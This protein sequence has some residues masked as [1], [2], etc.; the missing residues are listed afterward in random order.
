MSKRILL[1]TDDPGSGGVAQYNHA[2]LLGLVA[3]EYHVICVQSKSN[4]PLI[5][6]QKE[7]G[8]QHVWL[9]FDTSKDFERSL[10]N[11]ADA[12]N[13]LTIYK[14]DFII[15]SDCCPLSNFAAKQVAIELEIPYIAVI[16][17]VAAYLAN[18]FAT[19]LD[20]LARQYTQAKAVIAVSND[21]L[22]LLHELFRLPKDKGRVIYY[23]RPAEYFS[24]S[25]LPVRQNLRQ[26]FN[27]PLNA[28]VCFTS[29]RLELVKGYQYQL[30]AI[31]HLKQNEVWHKLY[32]VWAGA[33]SLEMQLKE[34]IEQLG[35]GNKV[36]LLGQRWD[37]TDWLDASDIFILP[38]ELEGMP[39]CIMEAMAK[40]LPVI[41]SAVSG[42]PEEL[43]DT[44]KL[45]PSPQINSQATVI[46][47]V[48]TIQAWCASLGLRQSIGWTCKKRAEEMFRAERMVVET[49]E[50]IERTLLPIGDY[51][52]PGFSIIQPDKC[53]PNLITGD[54]N[55][56]RWP[57]LRRDI[58][59]NWYVDKRQPTVGFLNRD[60]VHILYNTALN[61][62]G[63]KALE[64]GCWLGWS[65]CHLALAG[66]ELDVVDPL[67]DR[68]EFYESV[69]S[70][71]KAAGV[72]DSVNLVSGYSPQKVEELAIQ[73]QRKWS[74]IFIDGNHDA[75]FP[76]KDA[77]ICEQLAEK[78][79]LILFH[80]LVSPDVAQ[81]LKYLKQKRWNT[82]VYQTMQIMGVAWRGNVKPVEH[83]P[84]LKVSKG[85][86]EH[87]QHFPVSGLNNHSIKDEFSEVFNNYTDVCLQ[88]KAEHTI[89]PEIKN[90]E[91]FYNIQILIREEDIKTILEIGSSTGEG[92]T[93]A[94]VTAIRKKLD[95]PTLFCMEVAKPRFAEL[96]K[97]YA[98]DSFVKCYNISSVSLQDF[99]NQ[100]EV[101][102]FYDAH[103]TNLNYYSLDRILS[104]LHQDIECIKN[105]K[106]TEG[107]IKKIKQENKIHFFDVV[108]IDGSE[109]TG[110][111]E[112]D[113][114]YGA[115]LVLLDDINTFKNYKNYRRLLADTNYTLV[116]QNF[117]LR[118]G[119]AIFKKVDN[120]AIYQ[121]PALPI[122]FF[123]I[124]LN[125]EPFIRYHI[126]VFKQLP[127]QW[128]WHII[129]GVAELKHDT[130]WSLRNGGH[131]TNEFHRNGRSNDGTT[132][133][134]DELARLYPENITVYRKPE[135]VFWDGKRQMVNAPLA[136]INEECLLWQVDA[137]EL[138][139]VEQIFTA[140]KMFIN[141][142]DKTAAF[143]WCWYFV[144]ENLVISTRNCYSQN[145]QQEWL[146]TW[147]FKPGLAWATHEPPI[148]VE[149][150]SNG[151][152]RNVAA[153][154]PFL[155]K[156]TENQGLVFQHFA[157]VTL[158]QLKFKEQYYGYTNAV[159]QWKA[160]QTQHQFPVLL[161]ECCSW[162]QDET[163]VDTVESSGVEPIAKREPVGSP[164]CSAVWR[165]LQPEGFNR[166]TVQIKQALPSPLIIVDGV[167][168]QLYK[169]GIAR[170]WLSLLEEWVANGFAEHVIVLDRAGTAPKIP[171]IRYRP[172]LPY[173]YARTDA[174]REM[175]QHVC[176]EEGADLFIS[177][178]YTTPLST[179]SVFLAHDMIPEL[180]EWDVEQPMW[181]EKH[182]GIKNASAYI[183]VSENTAHDLIRFFPHVSVE[184]V[185]VAHNGVD[186]RKFSTASPEDIDRFKT[187]YGISKPYFIL[188]GGRG[189]Y[190]NTILFFQAFAQLYSRYGFEIV[191][192]G[193]GPV[194]ETEFR[195]Y[196][197]GSVVHMLTLNDEE[198]SVAYSGALALVYPSKY[199]GFGLPVLEA[200]AC[201]C[202]VITC[203]NASIP[204]VAGEAALY[205]NDDDVDGLANA[206]CDVQKPQVRNSL[207]A[208]GLGQAKK[209]SWTKMAKTV[210]SALIDATLLSLNLRDINLIVFPDWSQTEE[211][212]C[213][214]LERVIR[215]I[216]THPRKSQM[217]LLVNIENTPEDDAALVLSS[218]TMNLLLQEDLDASEGPEISS[219]GQLGLI[220]W[221]ALLPRIEARII[222]E[223][224]DQEA[225]TAV[226]AEAL[227][228]YQLDNLS[229]IE[230]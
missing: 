141:N 181:R 21:N 107:G 28:V 201:G 52:S 50:V 180:M 224:E 122:H 106:T 18:R 214:E 25:I 132:E 193:S 157:Y 54:T 182:Y 151:Q 10:I 41:A 223:N 44:G 105:F 195:A 126:N 173:N 99:P 142:P 66:V 197:S 229:N 33:G 127:F 186:H 187:K 117:T 101:I 205:V 119:Y 91:F 23:G 174:D 137:D 90:D 228:A 145:P 40:G 16:G 202:P 70:S 185:T 152:Q 188:V 82:L 46:E 191:C 108:L 150:L 1:Y 24:T 42:I 13:T 209:F 86:P 97:R 199:E 123:T 98:N 92:S 139:T 198:L 164:T 162:V 71:L 38:S 102:A 149:T 14:P 93:E 84:D 34:T 63:K 95:K 130:A 78:D 140:R 219:V 45:L 49:V 217:T 88:Q 55:V 89:L 30:E 167:F 135:G 111:A 165:F 65:A 94:F 143:Y 8:I 37:I 154:N 200:I 129:E 2:I 120:E 36:K 83:Y 47:L 221:E 80:D 20:E 4:N 48:T 68:T 51:V 146:R 183:A 26:E 109:F 136:N 121:S 178:Y 22:T 222:L 210:S 7:L 32:F 206:L 226:K 87:L 112:L 11:R 176:D 96:Q 153:V 60:E 212:L 170:V 103:Q 6:L 216:T 35:V 61:F 148:L 67:L 9:E 208:A 62:K 57:H 15:F 72:F 204:E 138:W 194:L 125:G 218:V 19:F 85:L 124:V 160:L 118:N 29:A 31:K 115:K 171:G 211:S 207:I 12:E 56:C 27:I 213:S 74:L 58:P 128:H 169:T 230:V 133:Y 100:D 184:S 196:T 73:L 220:Q 77:I 114:V 190:K 3:S 39:L 64:I 116:A 113:E 177:S 131:V 225:T 17:F 79:A 215:A 158:K 110:I 203:P 227:R 159:S 156:E 166:K 179:P 104:W 76:L 144:G 81:G 43:G 168:F 175:L 147:R 75:P 172:V 69:S 59:H 134:L 155:H 189:G 192:T 161:R 163:L 5:N 53:F